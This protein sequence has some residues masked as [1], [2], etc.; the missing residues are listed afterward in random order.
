[1]E[2]GDGLL[3]TSFHTVAAPLSSN[4]GCLAC[5]ESALINSG[6]DT[7]LGLVHPGAV[8]GVA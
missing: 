2:P 1:M 3:D 6:V 4:R 7:L 5:Y 8:K